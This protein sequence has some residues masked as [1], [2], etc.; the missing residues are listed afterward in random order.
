MLTSLRNCVLSLARDKALLVWA[1]AFP[2]I[3]TCIF[4]GMFSSIQ[5]AYTTVGSSLGVVRDERYAAAPGLD[6]TI[7]AISDPTSSD[8]ACDV[9]Y[10]DSAT[11]AEAA[12]AAAK[13]DAYLT[14]D[15]DGTPQLHV[16]SK[17]L[18]ENGSLPTSVL[19]EVLDTYLHARAAVEKVVE[20]RPE[21]LATGEAIGSF[22]DGAVR[23]VRLTATKNP[24]SPD[25]RYYYALLAM[26]AGMGATAGMVSVRRLLPCA[27]PLGARQALAAVP[28]WRMLVGALLGAWLCEFA[29]LVVAALYMWGVAG[30]SFGGDAPGVMI[31]LA[32]SSLMAC[33]AGALCRT[34]P[35]ME[36][37]MVSGITCLLSLFT[38]LYGTASQQ[39]ADAVEAAAPA[40][41][42]ANPLWQTTNCFYALLYYDTP[43][44]FL[45]RVAT[46]LAMAVAFLA[47]AAVRMRRTSYDHL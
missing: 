25:A 46:L 44:A 34:V 18:S 35:R 4:M 29:C 24:P 32:A 43:D 10:Y 41:A 19:S 5:D 8:R 27:G 45:E 31:A 7:R 21:L 11:D 33:S 40:L 13:V 3:M 17:S 1:L 2:L 26:A 12:A 6:E 37:G 20:T 30:V 39:L 14:V 16:T 28:R 47:L 9:T 36:E 23:T 22:T 15:V 38:G 42:H